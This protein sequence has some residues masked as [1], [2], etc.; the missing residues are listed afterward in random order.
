MQR[1]N[2]LALSV[3][4]VVT[5]SAPAAAQP[6]TDIYVGSLEVRNGRVTVGTLTNA[7]DRAGYDNQPH[8]GPA[9]AYI[10]YTSARPDGQT[11]IYRYDLASGTTSPV[12][13]TAESEYSPTLMPGEENF[14]VI[15]VEADSTQ[16]LWRFDL[17]GDNPALVLEHI[18]PVGYHAWGNDFTLALFVLGAPPTLQLAHSGTGRANVL[19][20]NIGRSLH[21]IPGQTAISFVHKVSDEE[22]WIRRLDLRTEQITSLTRTLPESEDYAW[23]PQ[24]GGIVL[25]GQG[26]TLHQWSRGASTWSVVADFAD[27]GVQGITRI[28]VSRAGDRIAIVGN[29]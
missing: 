28:A 27:Q 15:R 29:R 2:P 17:N 8:F 20:Q 16:R 21:R 24:G 7:T 6:G 1:L 26:S 3:W 14:S 19:E 4:A 22:W 13:R 9:G 11:D 25:M 18:E 10:L 5:L 12:T 23:T